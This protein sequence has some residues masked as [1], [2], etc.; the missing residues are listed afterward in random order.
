MVNISGTDQDIDNGKR[1]YQNAIPVAV[2]ADD[3]DDSGIASDKRME[4]R[5]I[6]QRS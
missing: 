6:H 2:A 5:K 3:D 4:I 1:R